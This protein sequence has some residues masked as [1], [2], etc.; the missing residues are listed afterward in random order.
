MS[1]RRQLVVNADD[2]GFTPDV[3]SGIVEAHRRGILTATT[4]M[5]NGDAFDDAVRL[6]RETPSLDVGCHLVLIGGRSL[7]FGKPLPATVAELLRALARREIPVYEEL[8]AQ[9]RR[10]LAA[11]IRPTHVDTHKHTHLAP[12]V[13]DAV[14]RISRHFAIPWVRSPF[15]FPMRA[16]GAPLSTRLE[17]R[18]LGLM[19][20]RFRRVLA[21]HGCRA[22]G[23]FTGF[24][25]TGLVS[26]DTLAALAEALPE[27]VTELMCHPGHCGDALRHAPTR[28]KESR[29]RELQA[30]IAPE[31]RQVFE[32]HNI[33]LV[34]YSQLG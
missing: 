25:I 12:P 1:W 14:A 4:L 21:A 11:G 13:L 31:T 8:A 33:E 2:F 22:T 7:T 27:G 15:D 19:Q 18:A 28:L 23:H 30:L 16:R 10:I 6:A 29:E 20:A 17:S 5:A 9:T 3:N 26:C 34:N 24:R 32:R